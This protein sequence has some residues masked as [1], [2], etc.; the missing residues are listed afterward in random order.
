[1][2]AEKPAK[3]RWYQFSLRSLLLVI[4][5]VSGLLAWQTHRA[6]Q[7][8]SAVAALRDLGVKTTNEFRAP[9][10][11][12]KCL[13]ERLGQTAVRVSLFSENLEAAIPR[14]QALPDMEEVE[15]VVSGPGDHNRGIQAESLLRREMPHLKTQLA[16]P[17]ID[18][19]TVTETVNVPDGAS[20]LLQGLKKLNATQQTLRIPEE[21]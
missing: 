5:V 6:Q 13:G 8:A 20:I 17:T 9:Q 4:T 2:D 1:M 18:W 19:I 7:Q 11:L 16:Y 12:S 15:V 10:W 21:E 3:L 14:L